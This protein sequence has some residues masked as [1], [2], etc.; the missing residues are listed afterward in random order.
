MLDAVKLEREKRKTE[1]LERRQ[2]YEDRVLDV[3]LSPNVVRLA[4]V[5]GMIAYRRKSP[6]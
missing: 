4:M 6:G 3:L 5:A 2:K 1:R